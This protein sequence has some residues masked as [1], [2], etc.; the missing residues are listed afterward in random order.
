MVCVAWEGVELNRHIHEIYM[1]CS[2]H[3]LTRF[4]DYLKAHFHP[5][6]ASNSHHIDRVTRLCTLLEEMKVPINL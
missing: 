2:T 4:F 1:T 3:V 6:A 5:H